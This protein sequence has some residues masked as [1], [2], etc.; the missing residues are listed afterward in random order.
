MI[1]E[2]GPENNTQ[3]DTDHNMNTG[4]IMEQPMET[5]DDRDLTQEEVRVIIEDFNLRKTPG[6]DGIS[7]EILRPLF[8][9]YP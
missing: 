3:E 8:K 6:P 4:R 7:S 5:T 1:E 9:S 2:L